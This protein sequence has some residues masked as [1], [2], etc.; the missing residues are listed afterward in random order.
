MFFD[1][2]KC[3]YVL[4]LWNATQDAVEVDVDLPV[5]DL[6]TQVALRPYRFVSLLV[7]NGTVEETTIL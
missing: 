7:K 5:W 1:V 4:H 3:G 2:E 6:Q